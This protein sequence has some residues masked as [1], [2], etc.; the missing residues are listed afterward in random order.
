MLMGRPQRRRFCTWVA[1][2]MPGPM[3]ITKITSV[4]KSIHYCHYRVL[5]GYQCHG[6]ATAA[7]ICTW[8]TTYKNIIQNDQNRDYA[9]RKSIHH[10]VLP[11][12]HQCHGD[13][14]DS[15]DS[16]RRWRFCAWPYDRHRDHAG[17]K[18][19]HYRVL[20]G[21]QCHNILQQRR[22]VRWRPIRRAVSVCSSLYPVHASTG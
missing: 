13:A 5:C 18:S 3:T 4:L 8:C 22:S 15:C 2:P 10:R 14:P 7:V 21:Y 1:L 11:G 19:I 16:V 20:C 9:A 12:A 6:M 17:R